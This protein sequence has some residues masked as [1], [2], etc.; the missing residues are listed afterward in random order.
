MYR[1]RN[2]E[3]LY[4]YKKQVHDLEW[5]CE[6]SFKE[7]NHEHNKLKLIVSVQMKRDREE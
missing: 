5:A 7:H 1:T 3:K 2:F 6:I 4:N